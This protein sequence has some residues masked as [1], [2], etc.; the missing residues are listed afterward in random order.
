MKESKSSATQIQLKI[1]RESELEREG[2]RVR[3]WTFTAPWPISKVFWNVVFVFNVIYYIYI[4]E[5]AVNVYNLYLV[6]CLILS[7]GV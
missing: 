5:R 1:F 7:G 2:E 6:D 4:G 3:D